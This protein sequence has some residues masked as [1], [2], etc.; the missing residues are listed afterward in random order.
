MWL[1][2]CSIAASIIV[3]PGSLAAAIERLA[4]EDAVAL[5]FLSEA[6]RLGLL[7]EARPLP[8]RTARPVIGEGERVVRQDFGICMTIAAESPLHALLRATSDVLEAAL[9]RLNP[10]PLEPPLRLNDIVVQRYA[11]G[12]AGISPHRDHVRYVGLVALVPL[13]GDGQLYVCTRRDGANA[14]A[15]PAA[16]G[17][18]VL[19]RAPGLH[20][21]TDRPFHGLRAITA[22][23]YSVGLR[24]DSTRNDRG[25]LWPSSPPWPCRSHRR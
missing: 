9:A 18:L 24:Q 7:A 21:R 23:R 25:E 17:D 6:A 1:D 5:P 3:A 20:G 4:G 22:E 15:V 13:A 16:P 19:M 10:R 8:Y 12:S 2:E 11:P 14:Y